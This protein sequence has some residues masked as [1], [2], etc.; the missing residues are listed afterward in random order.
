MLDPAFDAEQALLHADAAD[1]PLPYPAIRPVDNLAMW[2]SITQAQARQQQQQQR[3]AQKAAADSAA[4]ARIAEPAAL[5]RMH[6]SHPEN[7]ARRGMATEAE[8]AERAAQ[9]RREYEQGRG[10][11]V[12]ARMARML[13]DGVVREWLCSV[14]GRLPFVW[15]QTKMYT[16]AESKRGEPKR[17]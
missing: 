9:R 15:R 11:H 4:I 10:R 17:R 8:I 16:Q 1:V 13:A 14:L 2:L 5:S 3:D 7:R 12:L 6:P